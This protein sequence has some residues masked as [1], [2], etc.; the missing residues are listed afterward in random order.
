MN[1]LIFFLRFMNWFSVRHLKAHP[2]RV[3]A[4][5]FGIALGAAVF[6][7]V[8]L[9]VDAS[10]DAFTRSMDLISGKAEWT[11]VKAAGRVPECL[12]AK[13][14]R[15]PA[16][17]AASPLI[18]TYVSTHDAAAEPFLLIGLDPIL[19]YTLR[20]WQILPS[21]GDVG[22][23]W[24]DFVTKPGTLLMSRKL[25]LKAGWKPGDEVNLEHVHQVARFK[26]IGLL[27]LEGLSLVEGG[28]VAITDIA[29]IQ[30]FMGL[31]GWVDRIDLRLKPWATEKDF[32]ELRSLLPP[33]VT[34]EA[35]FQTKETGEA[36]I[37]AY[38]INLSILSLV[39]LFV[40]MFLVYSLVPQ[41]GFPPAG[42]SHPALSRCIIQEPVRT[43][44]F[45]RL[46][47]GNPW[48][49]PRHPYRLFPG[50]IPGK[51]RERYHH[52]SLC[53]RSGRLTQA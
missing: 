25:A 13:L 53:P 22:R 32:G 34:L 19:D 16:V 26:V 47:S 46:H 48:V 31:Q 21:S 24:L 10:L 7:S 35:P 36:M 9:A 3:F 1:R 40:G 11:V 18:S 15:H 23:T 50:Q 5:L 8:R 37:H 14:R 43:D 44:P 45:G 12:V 6:T 42:I 20:E 52:Q 38:Q 30:E 28:Y 39:S 2:W 51:W 49:D 33:G 4:V 17:E 41:C 27:Q 29:T